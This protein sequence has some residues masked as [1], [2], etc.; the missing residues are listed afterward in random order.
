M[1]KEIKHPT[2]VLIIGRS[3]SGKT[4][5]GVQ[6]VAHLMNQV[7]ECIVCS[8]TYERQPTWDKLRPFVTV[9]HDN[10]ETVLSIVYTKIK[11]TTQDDKKKKEDSENGQGKW[12]FLD[13]ISAE[14]VKPSTNNV[15]KKASPIATR[16][17]LVMDDVSYER[18]LNEGNKG[19]FNGLCYNARWWNISILV[20]CHK[21][22]NIGAGM[23]E[24]LDHLFIF[25][26]VNHKERKALHENYGITP[27]LKEL[28]GVHRTYFHIPIQKGTNRY[29]FIYVNFEEG[30][31][32][33]YMMK[34][35]LCLNN[36]EDDG[37]DVA[38]KMS[39]VDSEDGT[40]T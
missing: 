12:S 23:K 40:S 36:E 6:L 16:R 31:I 8:P 37:D 9:N 2:R 21:C 38:A 34:E 25:N 14:P 30:G 20:I 13:M 39:E 10:L 26:T 15:A 5:L 32:S 28:E 33:Y 29:P 1:V 35:R 3:L 22:S 27:S 17:L 19:I 18:A 4:T 11:N 7:D 24:N